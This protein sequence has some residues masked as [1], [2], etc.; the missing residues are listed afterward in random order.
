M[1]SKDVTL[2]QFLIY[3]LLAMPLAIVGLPL[4]IYLPTFYATEVGV[5]IA[6]VGIVLFL[7]RVT[8][9]ITDPLIGY[10]SDLLVQKYGSRKP[11]IFMGSI[12][13]VVSFYFLLH[14]TLQ[15]P[16]LW[17]LI[18]SI[19]IYLGW[20]MINIPYITFSSEMSSSYY[21]KTKLNTVREFSTILGLL[22]ALLVPYFVV[23]DSIDG[24]L[25]TIY[26]TFLTLFTPFLLLTLLKLK[27]HSKD[28]EHH[29]S[30]TSIKKVYSSVDKL[31][32]LQV[33]YFLNNL[34]NAIPATLFLLFIEVVI[35]D[36]EYS[37]EILLLYF[38]SGVIALPFWTLLS[39]KIGKKYVWMLSM[40]LAASSF[41]FVLF[42]ERSDTLLF[43]IIS[44]VSGLSLG[45]D[46]AF[47]TSMQADVV[48]KHNNQA[49]LLFG[50]WN[51]ITKFAL[52]LSVVISFGILGLVDFDKEHLTDYS[53]LTIT[54]LYGL[55]PVVLK[56]LA[57]FFINR[58]KE[59][60]KLMN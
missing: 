27:V 28:V 24:K 33:A 18:F 20:S 11:M 53:I 46:I 26:I 7:A 55:L 17:L 47:P 59:D 1:N 4:Y 6:T 49:G 25:S 16:T 57:L 41:S 30:F 32:F 48:Q 15:Y 23:S 22:V 9:V 58:Y 44:V 31:K 54:L 40:F 34:A 12:I 37:E 14:P 3:S 21:S 38:F 29:F 39:K 2:N 13:L 51:M 42:L 36:Q 52:A 43:G 8:D 50:I 60:T 45:A 35:Q 56:F 10:L 19:L 5:T